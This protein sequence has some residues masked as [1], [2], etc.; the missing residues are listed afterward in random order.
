MTEGVVDRVWDAER[1]ADEAD[2]L[3]PFLIV[4]P[5]SQ[6]PATLDRALEDMVVGVQLVRPLILRTC[7]IMTGGHETAMVVLPPAFSCFLDEGQNPKYI[8]HFCR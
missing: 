2:K 3:L 1:R 6:V 5:W 7:S 4:F 8:V